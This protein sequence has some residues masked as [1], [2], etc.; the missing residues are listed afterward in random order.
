MC[1]TI[2]GHTADFRLE[3]AEGVKR[4]SCS[5]RRG[6]ADSTFGFTAWKE[7]SAGKLTLIIL[8]ESFSG[9]VGVRPQVHTL[10]W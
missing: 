1:R 6:D 9:I 7:Q 8:K 10:N 3:E 2:C 4:S 5:Q